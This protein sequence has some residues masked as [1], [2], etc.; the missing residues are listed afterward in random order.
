MA[1]SGKDAREPLEVT[2]QAGRSGP[3]RQQPTSDLDT[4]AALRVIG[5]A[6]LF[7]MLRSPRF[8]QRLA[9][10]AVVLAALGRMGQENRAGAMA[11]LAA[12][13]KREIQRF[14][15]YAER[16]AGHLQRQAERQGRRLVRQAE[17]PL[18]D[19]GLPGQARP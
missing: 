5:L 6:V 2:T 13:N 10:G 12:W 9:I 8:Y 7:H 18:A 11:R 15:R 14:E 4:Q 1:R 16:Q 19:P 3:T 17:G